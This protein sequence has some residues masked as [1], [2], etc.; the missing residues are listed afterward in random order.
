MATDKEEEDRLALERWEA[1]QLASPTLRDVLASGDIRLFAAYI[2]RGFREAAA[3]A[4][5]Q[6][7][8]AEK[9]RAFVIDAYGGDGASAEEF[10]RQKHPLLGDQTPLARAVESDEGVADVIQLVGRALFVEARPNTAETRLTRGEIDVLAGPA[11]RTFFRIADLWSMTDEERMRTLGIADPAT[12]K[13]W[14]EGYTAGL[15]REGLERISYILGIFYAISVLLPEPA[16]ASGWIK[17]PNSAPLF[18]GRSALELVASGN[19]ADLA[20]VRRYLDAQLST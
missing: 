19:L 3:E 2:T 9:I 5:E 7:T 4:V 1:A 10:L 18:G 6:R 8:R 12:L 14:S 13:R 15:N 11:L 16:R 20:A 17:A